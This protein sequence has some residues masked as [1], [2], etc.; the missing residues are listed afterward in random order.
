[1]Y[2]FQFHDFQNWHLKMAPGDFSGSYFLGARAAPAFGIL[3]LQILI[4]SLVS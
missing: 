2:H 4:T 1:M 3:D